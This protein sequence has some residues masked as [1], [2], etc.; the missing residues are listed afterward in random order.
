MATDARVLQLWI[1]PTPGGPMVP[2]EQLDARAGQG[3]VGDH[4][5]GRMRHVTLLLEDDWRAAARQLGRDDVDPAGRRANVLLCGAGA[6]DLLDCTVRLGEVEL[7]IRGETRPC[8][9]M[10]QAAPGMQAALQPHVR[11]GVW[12]RVLTD[13]RIVRGD[14][15]VVLAR[16]R[17]ILRP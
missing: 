10:E 15:L 13:G 8:P 9:V 7:T 14:P 16:A 2:C 5:F 6:E 17:T 12:A 4:S 11:A 3:L 1:R